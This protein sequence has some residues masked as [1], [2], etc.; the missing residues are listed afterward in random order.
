[1]FNMG[2]GTQTAVNC[3][4]FCSKKAENKAAELVGMCQSMHRPMLLIVL[5][6]MLE[7]LIIKIFLLREAFTLVRVAVLGFGA[8]TATSDQSCF[9]SQSEKRSLRTS[10]QKGSGM[11]ASPRDPGMKRRWE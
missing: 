8:M 9:V 4:Q 3:K 5:Q 2:F 11:S 1:M 10:F 6:N 7:K